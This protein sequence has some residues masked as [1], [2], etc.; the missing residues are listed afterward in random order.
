MRTTRNPR[1]NRHHYCEILYVYSGESDFHVQDR[2]LKLREGD[3]VVV[4]SHL[5]HR[6]FTAPRERIR[7]AALFFEPEIISKA[8]N[9]ES[10]E[11]LAAFSQQGPD[12]PHVIPSGESLTGEVFNLMRRI[13]GELPAGTSRACLA[14]RTY[15]RMILMLLVNYYATTLDTQAK[16]Y[17]KQQD[18][19]RLKPSLS[20]SNKI[21]R[22]LFVWKQRPNSV[23]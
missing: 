18:L 15:L 5:Y 1:A 3:V 14:V 2:C 22:N 4:G 7:V 13:Q 10:A 6:I 11:Y 17:R 20:I 19:N 23:P 21:S 8:S 9:G 12:F 16:L